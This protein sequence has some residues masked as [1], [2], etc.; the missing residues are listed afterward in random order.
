[1]TPTDEFIDDVKQSVRQDQ[2]MQALKNYGNI[3]ITV[4]ITIILFTGGYLFWHSYQENKLTKQTLLFEKAALQDPQD[5]EALDQLI[6]EGSQG[7]KI[8]ALLTQ[9]KANL[10]SFETAEQKLRA[11]QD[12]KEVEPFYRDVAALEAIMV[13]FDSTNAT[14]LLEELADLVNRNGPLQPAALELKGF[15]HTKLKQLSAAAQ[16]FAAVENHPAAP[17]NMKLRARAMQEI[18]KR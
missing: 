5:L 13:K 12:A 17:R 18:L 8:L 15:A 6:N 4:I 10:S 11:L 2:L 14:V 1:M 16:S 3:I 9:A 7:Y